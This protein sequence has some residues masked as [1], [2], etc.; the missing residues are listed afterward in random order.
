MSMSFLCVRHC[1]PG[2]QGPVSHRQPMTVLRQHDLQNELF[3][4]SEGTRVLTA[5]I[6]SCYPCQ[7]FP[8]KGEGGFFFCSFFIHIRLTSNFPLHTDF[9]FFFFAQICV[10]LILENHHTWFYWCACVCWI[11]MDKANNPKWL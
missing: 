5:V 1:F 10:F 8:C 4:Q 7:I 2:G 3:T 9:F 11:L 6:A